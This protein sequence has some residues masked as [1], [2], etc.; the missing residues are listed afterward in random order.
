MPKA[1]KPVPSAKAAPNYDDLARSWRDNPGYRA[2]TRTKIR[3]ARAPVPMARRFLQIVTAI[4]AEACVDESLNHYEF[5]A[6]AQLLIDPKVDRSG[7]AAYLGVD[8]TN[9]GLILNSLEKRG[10]IERT[11]NPND[12]RAQLMRMTALGEQAFMRQT[13]QVAKA[14]EKILAPLTK[15]ERETLYDLLEKVIA[16]N[17]QYSIPGAGRRKR[18]P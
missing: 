10:F 3:L 11:V 1:A 15:V 12:R 7:L 8:R 17:E 4:W 2:S 6:M 14:R 9:I 16:G 18:S 5:G 13:L